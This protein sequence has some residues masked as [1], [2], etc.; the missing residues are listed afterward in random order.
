M[1]ALTI[2]KGLV[3]LSKVVGMFVFFAVIVGV[4]VLVDATEPWRLIR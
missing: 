2:L 3:F 4:V 1:I